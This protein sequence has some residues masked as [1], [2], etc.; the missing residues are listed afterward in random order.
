MITIH[1]Q[2]AIY[3]Q[4]KTK[5]LPRTTKKA[6]QIT[7]I[8]KINKSP[9]QNLPNSQNYLKTTIPRNARTTQKQ[10]DFLESKT[11]NLETSRTS[12]KQNNKNNSFLKQKQTQSK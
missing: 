12:C 8:P 6:A 7:Q 11:N 2:K 10:N 5:P 9:K 3:D 1:K 4:T